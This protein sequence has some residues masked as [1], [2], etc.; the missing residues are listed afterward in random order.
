MERSP[1]RE[2]QKLGTT[3]GTQDVDASGGRL[4][5]GHISSGLASHIDI[6]TP[7]PD[8]IDV[9][10]TQ[11]CGFEF[12]AHT[13]ETASLLG[14]EAQPGSAEDCLNFGDIG[15]IKGL[16]DDLCLD[17]DPALLCVPTKAALQEAA[18]QGHG[19]TPSQH[20]GSTS[21]T[22][23]GVLDHCPKTVISG[24][25]RSEKGKQSSNKHARDNQ[26]AVRQR[27]YRE[28][29]R[30]Q[31]KRIKTEITD[32]KKAIGSTKKQNTE[33]RSKQH[34]IVSTLEYSQEA[35]TMLRDQ[36]ECEQVEPSL[37][38]RAIPDI[39]VFLEDKHANIG[40]SYAD[41]SPSV[42][43]A[44]AETDGNM[45]DTMMG[46]F[47]NVLKT[48]PPTS[49]YNLFRRQASSLVDA[50]EA[51]RDDPEKQGE[52]E[53]GMKDLFSMRA[54]VVAD[55]AKNQPEGIL[56]HLSDDP[57]G[58]MLR[59]CVV[60]DDPARIDQS[61]I[62]E[63]VKTLQLNNSQIMSL[64]DYWELF[65]GAWIK[66]ADALHQLLLPNSSL[67]AMHCTERVTPGGFTVDTNIDVL[68]TQ[69]MHGLMREAFVMHP[70]RQDLEDVS[71]S[72]GRSVLHLAE[73]IYSV[74]TPLQKARLCVSQRRAPWWMHVLLMPTNILL[75]KGMLIGNQARNTTSFALMSL[76]NG[77]SFLGSALG[78]GLTGL[79]GVTAESFDNLAP[80]IALC[81]LLTLAPLPF[82][83]L[84]PE[85][86]NKDNESEDKD[87]DDSDNNNN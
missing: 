13:L 40:I 63:L 32:L 42:Q 86:V 45:P 82:L 65:C 22:I 39:H 5:E 43:A 67:A 56:S 10:A 3:S 17:M 51:C 33:L 84:L 25:S 76:L 59:Q 38:T 31:E 83:K 20:H 14:M 11:S 55:M 77:G 64:C 52:V 29:K 57:V 35:Y 68:E 12:D 7:N 54:E 34:A 19:C 60:P 87:S 9:H 69:G 75:D 2:R 61:S 15:A 4:L 58:K 30:Q 46:M 41:G 66:S 80:L 50:Y 21:A 16:G 24:D 26:N 70:V 18:T 62:L 27:R 37:D 78:S 73:K 81:T 49:V 85:S 74:F 79:F 23:T 44:N 72:A 6:S 71:K 47:C 1:P 36:S 53:M 28:R 8:Y 48:V